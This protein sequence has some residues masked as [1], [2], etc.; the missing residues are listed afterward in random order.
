VVAVGADVEIF[1]NIP[2]LDLAIMADELRTVER[3]EELVQSEYEPARYDARR[4]WARDRASE[5]RAARRKGL[6]A[7]KPS[8]GSV[9]PLALLDAIDSGLENLG[10][11]LITTEQFA[12]PLE[13]AEA[14]EGGGSVDYIRPAGGS[15]G[16]GMGAPLG[17][18]LA[19]PDKPVV[20][21][22]GDGSVYYADSAFWSA[23]HHRIPVLY[24]IPNNGTYGI[25]AGAFDGAEGVMKD[26]G[27]Y[28]G[29]VL[30]GIDVVGIAESFGVEGIRVD[31]EAKIKEEVERGLDTVEKEGR[32]LLLDVR[33][34][35]GL[36]AGGRAAK[37]FTLATQ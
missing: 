33:L 12:I 27:E 16:Y 30:D 11:G 1:E 14:K 5:F 28:A 2:Q 34:P 26:T 36:P 4:E 3:L 37:Q 35:V 6:Q 29:V 18:K 32:P 17:A 10:G 8:T 15:E 9:R 31:D 19:A 7:D 25:V 24:V 21:L 22:V 13:C 20:G 23:A